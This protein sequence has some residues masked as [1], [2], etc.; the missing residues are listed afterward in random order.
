MMKEK[1]T[2]QNYK[3]YW[4]RHWR[5]NR[6]SLFGKLGGIYRKNIMAGALSYYFEHYFPKKGVFAEA[7]SGTSQTSVRIIK[8]RRKLVAV[9]ISR[10]ALKEAAKIP[11]IDEVVQADI[12]HLPFRNERVDGIWNL[13]VFE[14][15]TPEQ[16]ARILAEFR[17]VLKKNAP[18]II[19]WPPKYSLNGIIFRVIEFF[20]NIFRIGKKPFRFYPDEINKPTSMKQTKKFFEKNGFREVKIFFPWRNAFGDFVIVA[21]KK[22]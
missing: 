15:F 2:G 20:I 8:H 18:I 11:Q 17:R 3:T 9:D 19:F 22:K 13:G 10:H 5:K 12:F 7:G 4:D 16:D 1:K 14:H 6:E 21:K